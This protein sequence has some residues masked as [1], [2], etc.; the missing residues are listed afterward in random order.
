MRGQGG[1]PASLLPS[2]AAILHRNST[3]HTAI[4][5]QWHITVDSNKGGVCAIFFVGQRGRWF[6]QR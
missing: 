1:R 4:Y 5:W 3:G 6:L 2:L